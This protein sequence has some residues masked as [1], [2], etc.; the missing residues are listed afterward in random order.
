L[1]PVKQN[2]GFAVLQIELAKVKKQEI[3]SG[4]AADSTGKV[5]ICLVTRL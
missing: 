3:P 5:S 2:V 1:F 4:W